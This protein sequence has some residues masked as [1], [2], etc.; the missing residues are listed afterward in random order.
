MKRALFKITK[1]IRTGAVGV[2]LPVLA[3]SACSGLLAGEEEGSDGSG[4]LLWRFAYPVGSELVT[5]AGEEVPDTNSFL[6]TVK[7]ASGKVLYEGSYGASP[8]NLMVSPGSYTVSARSCNFTVPAFS[9]PQYGDDQVVVVKSGQTTRASLLCRQLNAGIRLRIASNFLTNYPSAT[10]HLKSS[11]GSLHYGYSEKRIAYFS[12]GPVSLL[13]SEDGTDRTLLT[14]SLQEQEI[15]T[16]SVSAPSASSTGGG[17]SIQ[18]DTT[19]SWTSDSFVIGSGGSS[20]GGGGTGRDPAHAYS[21]SE[22]KDHI[23]EEEVW[24][25]GYIVGGDL[26]SSGTKMNTTPPFESNTHLT[27][28]ERSSIKDKASCLSIELKKGVIRDALNLKDNPENLGQQV[29]LCGDIVEAYYGIP[30]L[31]NLSEYDW[32]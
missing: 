2:L 11:A 21:V 31:K 25:Y 14:R 1:R 12:P 4:T 13:L 15:L 22:A 26:S 19:R 28:A 9:K 30:G 24:V 20:G 17:F 18:I 3:F 29:F 10:L 32:P 27:I 23:G 7:D 5:R 8:S 6:L 16:L